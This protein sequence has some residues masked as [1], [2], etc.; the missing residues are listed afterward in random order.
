MEGT[1]VRNSSPHCNLDHFSNELFHKLLLVEK[2]RTERSNRSFILMLVD[3]REP[4]VVTR[5]PGP[6]AE[7]I[8]RV[9]LE[10]TRE[11]DIRGW[12]EGHSVAGVI[13]TEIERAEANS[14][15]DS[16][17]L[18]LTRSLCHALAPDQSQRLTFHFHIYPD[19]CDE[20]GQKTLSGDFADQ[21]QDLDTG[22][23]AALAVKRFIDIVGSIAGLTVLSPLIFLI[24][25]AIKITSKGPVLF[26]QERVG[27]HGRHFTFLKFRSMYFGNDPKIH[28]EYTRI[29]IAGEAST[30]QVAGD[31]KSVYKLTA[32]P[33]V[34][35]IGR[36]LR[37]S[38]L[39]E[40]PQF[41]NIL[42]GEMSL[43]GPRP[44]VTY[45]FDRYEL[46]HRQRLWGAKP[47]L[48]GLWQVEGRSTVKFDEMVRLDIRYA[49][50]WSL[51]LDF[52]ILLRTPM[53]VVMGSGAY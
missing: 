40:I 49:R 39:D 21:E 22:R 4:N 13:F 53:A 41:L 19:K 5:S 26:R 32:D 8:K 17:R 46:W 7:T 25:V 12:Y 28:E 3:S 34:T 33:R 6:V 43:V 45:E 47:G 35:S 29:L 10:S 44:P 48:T 31:G 9:L 15:L 2:K 1:R 14:V 24:A 18:R 27:Q 50:S 52:R 42:R 23:V 30:L 11:T 37:K 16:L 36:F 51:W 38:S 20:D